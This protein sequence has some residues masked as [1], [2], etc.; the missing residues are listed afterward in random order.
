MLSPSSAAEVCGADD[1]QYNAGAVL[2]QGAFDVQSIRPSQT[3]DSQSK[4][5]HPSGP[6]RRSTRV[7]S[8]PG[9]GDSVGSMPARHFHSGK[10]VE[11]FLSQPLLAGLPPLATENLSRRR[12]G[13]DI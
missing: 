7:N 1:G 8:R 4:Q 6:A 2:P 11:S 5:T 10:M 9:D 3:A 12:I 13:V